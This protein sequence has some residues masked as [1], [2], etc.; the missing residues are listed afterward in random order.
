MKHYLTS[1]FHF[2]R[3]RRMLTMKIDHVDLEIIKVLKENSKLSL[4]EVGDKIHLTGQAVGARI[5]KLI[6]SEIIE[7]FTI[8]IN[9]EKMGIKTTALIKIIHEYP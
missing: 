3:V 2:E 6:D 1:G 8:N 5:N 9:K 4:K 7:N